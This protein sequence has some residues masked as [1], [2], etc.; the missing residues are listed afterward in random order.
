MNT[1][2]RCLLLLPRSLLAAATF[3]IAASLAVIAP[4]AAQAPLRIPPIAAGAQIGVLVVTEPPEVLLDGQ[5]ARLSPGA[6]IRGRDNLLLMSGALVGQVLPVRY[7]RDML[8]LVHE[9]WVLNEFELPRSSPPP[10]SG[11]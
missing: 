10:V 7:V 6:R 11:P 1:M 3:A 9:V 8:G 2:N 4:A 5:P